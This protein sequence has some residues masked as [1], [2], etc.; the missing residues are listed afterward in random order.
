MVTLRPHSHAW[1]TAYLHMLA[2]PLS[3]APNA[4]TDSDG[5]QHNLHGFL[6]KILPCVAGEVVPPTGQEVVFSEEMAGLLTFSAF[7]PLDISWVFECAVMSAP[8]V[9]SP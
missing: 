7:S 4:L 9:A 5:S 1:L 6:R 2:W 8:V 3:L